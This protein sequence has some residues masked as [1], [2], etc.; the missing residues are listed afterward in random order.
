MINSRNAIADFAWNMMNDEKLRSE[1]IS[2]NN[3]SLFL[4]S[5]TGIALSENQGNNLKKYMNELKQKYAMKTREITEKERKIF[6]ISVPF[7]PYG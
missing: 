3:P 1:F 2:A 7:F 5:R 6:G 4:Q